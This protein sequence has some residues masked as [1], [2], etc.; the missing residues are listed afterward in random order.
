[1]TKKFIQGK[2]RHFLT[3][4]EQGQTACEA[5]N[6]DPKACS[7]MHRSVPCLS[8]YWGLSY[9]KPSVIHNVGAIDFHMKYDSNRNMEEVTWHWDMIWWS[10]ND[11]IFT[12]LWRIVLAYYKTIQGVPYHVHIANSQRE[13]SRLQDQISYTSIARNASQH[14]FYKPNA[15]LFCHPGGR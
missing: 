15:S 11:I 4:M 13:G 2:N 9:W 12:L 14:L 1:M 5:L 7:M 8:S 10:I 3:D 6:S